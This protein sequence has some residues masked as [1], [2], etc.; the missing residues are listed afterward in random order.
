MTSTARAYQLVGLLS[1]FFFFF[2]KTEN[3]PL[4]L[5][6]SGTGHA[7]LPS[8]WPPTMVRAPCSA[9]TASNLDAA[10][11]RLALE[12]TKSGRGGATSAACL[13][14]AEAQPPHACSAFRSPRG[15]RGPPSRVY[16]AS[17]CASPPRRAHGAS[18]GRG[19][20][21]GAG[22]QTERRAF[23]SAWQPL[24][25]AL[26]AA[27]RAPTGRVRRGAS[28][29]RTRRTEHGRGCARRIALSGERATNFGEGRRTLALHLGGFAAG[30]AR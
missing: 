5:S 14:L 24:A 16:G 3:E 18:V 27:V 30:S 8:A 22:R 19:A 15:P 4:S 23:F 28:K 6:V 20:L 2:W 12:S 29:G 10:A 13:A 21:K 7:P 25:V 11:A 17:K 9:A 26:P 1:F